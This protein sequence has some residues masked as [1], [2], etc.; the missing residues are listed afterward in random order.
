[1]KYFSIKNLVQK[2]SLIIILGILF[3]FS[4]CGKDV[5]HVKLVETDFILK[6][7][8]DEETCPFAKIKSL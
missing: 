7:P 4:S 8:Y 1:M 2:F 5:P 3:L 6:L